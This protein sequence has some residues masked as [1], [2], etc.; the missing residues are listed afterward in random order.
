MSH[1]HEKG[2]QHHHHSGEEAQALGFTE[3]MDKL[4]AHWIH[5]NEDHASNYKEWAQ[6]ATDEN[7]SE[8]AAKLEKA[9]F[10]TD[11]ITQVFRT[12]QKIL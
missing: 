1:Y 9:A 3:K 10:L 11:Q 2:H 12:A 6:R 8:I 4:L 5:H 7:Q